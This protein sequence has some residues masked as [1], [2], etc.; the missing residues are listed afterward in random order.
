[1]FKFGSIIITAVMLVMPFQVAAQAV[2]PVTIQPKRITAGADLKISYQSQQG[3]LKNS[4]VVY[5]VLY[6]FSDFE[7]HAK[8]LELKKS[9]AHWEGNYH[10]DDKDALIALKFEADSLQDTNNGLGYIYRVSNKNGKDMPGTQYAFAVMQSAKLIDLGISDYPSKKLL[11]D[12]EVKNCLADEMKHYP[13][14][15]GKI[16]YARMELLSKS[17]QSPEKNEQIKKEANNYLAQLKNPGEDD[18]LVVQHIAQSL[19]H[20]VFYADSIRALAAK[21][22]PAGLLARQKKFDELLQHNFKNAEGKSAYV[23]FGK[24]VDWATLDIISG[25]NRVDFSGLFADWLNN[26]Y[27]SLEAVMPKL[28]LAKQMNA[29]YRLITLAYQHETKSAEFLLPYS[30]MMIRQMENR[31]DRSLK[32]AYLSPRECKAAK[33]EIIVDDLY[34]H[35][36]LLY[37]CGHLPE[38]FPYIRRAFDVMPYQAAFFNHM[39]LK[40]LPDSAKVDRLA[41][42]EK[43]FATN[44]IT[45]YMLTRLKPLYIA[46]YGTDANYA[47]YLQKLKPKG[48]MEKIKKY[49]DQK[50]IDVKLS[51]FTL[52]NTSGAIVNSKDLLGK[53]VILDFWAT[54]CAPCKASFAGMKLAVDQYSRDPDVKFYFASTDEHDADYKDKITAFLKENDYNFN[55]LYDEKNPG[56]PKSVFTTLT[57][58]LHNNNNN[59]NSSAIPLKLFFDKTGKCRYVEV[60]YNGVPMD[61]ADEVSAIVEELRSPAITE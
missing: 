61:L 3:V 18:Y 40:T 55:V 17:L 57:D 30:A 20:N 34:M 41:F 9:G 52:K 50:M 36:V 47:D 42:I 1:M 58:D 35:G 10:I 13:A 60:G 48:E 46:K 43:C 38:A 22:N 16:F 51:D 39:Y 21:K 15:S 56:I 49:V 11:T 8:D 59:F 37:K 29:Y 19:L 33:D 12:E 24:N 7:W 5:G 6:V 53:I 14:S 44:E 45:D 25:T 32:E 31:Q 4:P 27:D 54:W 2:S 26:D 23:A 28:S